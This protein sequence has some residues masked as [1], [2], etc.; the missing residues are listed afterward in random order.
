MDVWAACMC[1]LYV[2]VGCMHVWAP[3]T[4]VLHV[5]CM[6]MWTARM[7]GQH[8]CVV[9]MNMW[10]ARSCGLHECMSCVYV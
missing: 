5:S 7:C 10:A 9:C 2:C 3:W 6:D 4:C 1:G 8:G